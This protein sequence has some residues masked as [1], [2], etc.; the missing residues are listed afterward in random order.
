VPLSGDLALQDISPTDPIATL[1]GSVALRYVARAGLLPE[2]SRQ[3]YDRFDKAL[4]EAVLNALDAEATRVDIDLSRIGADRE[5]TVIDDGVGMSMPEFCEQFMS[6]GGS[7]KFGNTSR[8]GRIGIG[9]LSLLQY[10]E[11]STVETKRAG[12]RVATRARI[13]HPWTL[14][15][16]ERCARLHEM[17]AGTAEEFAYDGRAGD[18][19]TRIRLENVNADVWAV[20]QD[21]TACYQLLDGLRRILPLRWSDGRLS[22]ALQQVAPDL[23]ATLREH[24][25]AWS[26]AVY[27]HSLWERDVELCRRTFGDD[28]AGVEDWNGPPAGL[29]KTIRVR[30]EGRPREITVAGFLISQKRAQTG[31]SGLTAR[32]QN[33]AVEEH[34]FFDVSSDPGFRKYIT[35]EVWILG[36]IDR[37][38]LIN[39]D[40]SSFNRECVDYQ[41][42]QRVMS[43]VI[44]DFKARSVQRPQRQKVEVRRVLED[45]VRALKAIEKVANRAA[46]VLEASGERGLPA[47]EPGRSLRERRLIAETLVD[48]GAEVIVD[49]DRPPS[50]LGY[51]LEV[52][53]DGLHVRAIVGSGI[54]EPRVHIAGLEYRIEYAVASAVDHP[55]VIRNRPRQIVFN[56]THP[57]HSGGDGRRKYEMSLALE[58]A[59]LLDSSDASAVYDQMVSFLEVL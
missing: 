56:T 51:K 14:D 2:L 43:R 55:L 20:G 53:A 5:I 27:V 11:A 28:G 18:H 35:G 32:V 58:L 45:H 48:A 23:V 59:Y 13:Q 16:D 7:S 12:S 44:V 4:R 19:F 6:L 25:D 29:I 9:S 57:V 15:R 36:E 33:V 24:V 49:P 1:G 26:A 38:R 50:D 52:S 8:F 34:T 46:Q 37:D 41:A 54:T 47:S 22:Q 42:V 10:A 3:T 31:W 17:A 40:R 21:P 30:G 39:I